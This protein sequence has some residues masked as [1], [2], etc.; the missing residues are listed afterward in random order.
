VERGSIEELGLEAFVSLFDHDNIEAP[1]HLR[2][3]QESK[4]IP[5]SVEWTVPFG[6]AVLHLGVH[7]LPVREACPIMRTMAEVTVRKKGSD[8]TA[9]LEWLCADPRTLVVFNHPCWDEEGIGA[10]RHRYRLYIHALELNNLRPWSENREAARLARATGIPLISGGDRHARQ[11]N[12]VLNVT[13]ASSFEEFRPGTA[14][15]PAE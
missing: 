10:E 8:L 3:L 13:N 9:I 4:D 1:M 2:V 15:R 12:A 14:R 5:I 6:D 7:N 11:P